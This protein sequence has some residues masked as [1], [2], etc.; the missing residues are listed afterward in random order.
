MLEQAAQ[1][2]T[3]WNTQKHEAGEMRSRRGGPHTTTTDDTFPKVD[4]K[5]KLTNPEFADHT[6]TIHTQ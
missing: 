5:N 3:A 6:A 4:R 1:G 2:E